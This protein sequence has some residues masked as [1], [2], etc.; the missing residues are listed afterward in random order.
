[1]DTSSSHDEMGSSQMG[2]SP[3]LAI[4]KDESPQGIDPVENL[5]EVKDSRT[6]RWVCLLEKTLINI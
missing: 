6:R 5:Q 3:E 4:L 1:M 2:S